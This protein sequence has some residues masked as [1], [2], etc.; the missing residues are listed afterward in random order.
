LVVACALAGT[1]CFR[2]IS[3]SELP[4][5]P[6]ALI[7]DTPSEGILSV[8]QFRQALT[9]E[10]P[11]DDIGQYKQKKLRTSLSL[12]YLQTGEL[13]DVPDVGAGGL[14][15][16]WSSDG[17]RLLV[18][19]VDPGNGM[20]GLSAW[21]PLTGARAIPARHPSRLGPGLAHP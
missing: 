2:S 10:S 4:T 20:V 13:H 18:A 15:L 16:D 5:D 9:I 12:L 3:Q 11:D 17:S 19:R 8:D 21:D 7:R 14:P 6:I 1:G